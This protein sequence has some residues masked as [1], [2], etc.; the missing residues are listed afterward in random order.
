MLRTLAE[1][2]LAQTRWMKELIIPGAKLPVTGRS[3]GTVM[4]T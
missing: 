1:H 3:L 4:P 2:N